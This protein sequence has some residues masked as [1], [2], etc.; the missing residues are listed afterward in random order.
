MI[1]FVCDN[2][3]ANLKIGNKWA[4]LLG[5]CP[6]CGTDTRVPGNPRRT[7]KLVILLRL[8]VAP[9]VV[10][11]FWCGVFWFTGIGGMAWPFIEGGLLA[12]AVIIGFLWVVTN[13]GTFILYP[14]EYILWRKGGGDP[15]FDTLLAPFNFDPPEVAY[16]ELYRKKAR[17]EFGFAPFSKPPSN[18]P[19]SD[20][21]ANPTEGLL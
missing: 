20:P 13:V 12:Y 5:H 2:C 21:A 11:G 1:D 6:H 4:G 14:C 8:A 15:F 19:P 17:R 18:P 10:I 16:Q 3:R 9:A 7:S